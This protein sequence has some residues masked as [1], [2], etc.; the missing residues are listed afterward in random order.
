MK[1][2]S[3]IPKMYA[4]TIALAACTTQAKEDVKV[5]NKQT[6]TAQ[7][8]QAHDKQTHVINF[9]NSSSAL[10]ENQKQNLEVMIN[11]FRRD[12]K[13]ASVIVSGWADREY[14]TKKGQTL[15]YEQR[16]LAK[17][18]IEMVEADLKRMG[19]SS[20]ETHSMAEQPGW[21]NKMFNSKDTVMKGEGYVDSANDKLV[22]DIGKILNSQGGPGRVV[23][24][25]RRVGDY[26]TK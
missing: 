9:A 21:M 1:I 17:E 20:I 26:G 23:I 6:M 22:S 13:I 16:T 14:P 18:R 8:D 7:K 24:I 5:A 11:D 4:L 19:I 3:E 25:V 10:E 15:S 12:A 2:T